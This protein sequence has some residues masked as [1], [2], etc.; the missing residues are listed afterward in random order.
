MTRTVTKRH[1]IIVSPLAKHPKSRWGEEREL[2]ELRAAWVLDRFTEAIHEGWVIPQQPRD[3]KHGWRLPPVI[4]FDASSIRRYG[5]LDVHDDGIASAYA[6]RWTPVTNDGYYLSE[7]GVAHIDT[8]LGRFGTLSASRATRSIRFDPTRKTLVN[9]EF[10]DWTDWE[11]Q[12]WWDVPEAS[13]HGDAVGQFFRRH[14]RVVTVPTDHLWLSVRGDALG[15]PFGRRFELAVA[16]PSISVYLGWPAYLYAASSNL[17]PCI[18]TGCTQV[19]SAQRDY[20]GTMTC[21]RARSRERK[22]QQRLARAP[23]R[24]MMRSSERY[25]G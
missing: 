4:E 7:Q 18:R 8:T 6:C 2:F 17:H 5:P 12:H 16:A 11:N 20:C 9:D 13:W 14:V 19:A 10:K 21:N 1:V 15:I 23:K 3:L 25:T 24:G 22:R